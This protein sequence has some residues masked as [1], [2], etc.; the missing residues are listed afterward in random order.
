MNV[1]VGIDARRNFEHSEQVNHANY[2]TI[3]PKCALATH[4]IRL[5]NDRDLGDIVT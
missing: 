2:S 1:I 3:A 5:V 4:Q